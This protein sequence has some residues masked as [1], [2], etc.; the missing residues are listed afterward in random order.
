M[1]RAVLAALPVL[2][3]GLAGASI[4]P[5]LLTGPRGEPMVVAPVDPAFQLAS[6][7]GGTCGSTMLLAYGPVAASPETQSAPVVMA[8]RLDASGHP[9]EI[10]QIPVGDITVG[11]FVFV[12]DASGR[13]IA[14][15]YPSGKAGAVIDCLETEPASAAD[16]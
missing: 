14:A 3:L 9:V 4:G 13:I 5:D 10:E 7:D 8:L 16:I 1:I 11:T 15:G 12:F 2:G 6:L